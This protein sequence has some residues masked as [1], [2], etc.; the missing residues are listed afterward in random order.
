MRDQDL[1]RRKFL[2]GSCAAAAGALLIPRVQSGTAARAR[3]AATSPSPITGATVNPNVYRMS[4]WV[5]G[6]QTF[7]SYVGYPLASTIQKIYMLE[8]QYYKDPLPPHIAQLAAAGC[9]FIVC[10][11]PSA[12]ADE[13]SQL[14]DFLQV[15]N[16]KGI[17]Y[18]AAL[19][20]EWNCAKKFATP[21]AY[22]DYWS[23]Y[24]PVVQDAGVPV[25]NLVCA[26]STK[27]AYAKIEPG[28]PTDPLPDAYWIDYYATA[29]RFKVR[30]D[31]S[32]GLLD[33]A[34]SYGVPVGV[35]EFGW[36]AGNGS[37]TMQE[38]DAYCPYLAG[39]ASR[40]PLGCLYWG[41]PGADGQDAV[42]SADDPKIPG[43]R[44]VVSAFPATTGTRLS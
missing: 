25:C 6:A 18:Q 5:K 8:G 29:Y 16:S 20:N 9:Q 24:A 4:N 37:L 33:Q 2:L 40:L 30:L 26:S 7:D 28:F 23:Q 43:I 21:R 32:G 41:D 22:L 38:W 31:A 44:Q 14:S 36:S 27:S 1:S 12:T 10:V 35:A 15:L 19:V 39:L 11:Y 17:V 42:T 3:L 34:E 13:S